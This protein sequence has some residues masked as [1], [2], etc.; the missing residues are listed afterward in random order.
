MKTPENAIS[1][2]S[3]VWIIS[4]LWDLTCLAAAPLA[5]MPLVSLLVPRWVTPEQ[6][7]LLVIAFASV[8]HH[9]PGFLRAYGERDLFFR[10]KWRFLLAPPLVFALAFVFVLRRLHG[11]EL[12]LLLWATWHILMQTYGFMRI[13]DR[14]IG[15]SDRR[16]ATLDLAACLAIFAIGIVFSDAR[17]YGLLEVAWLAG[18]PRVDP[19]LLIIARYAV[20]T[21]AAL[22]SVAYVSNVVWKWNRSGIVA[23]MKLL[24]IGSTAFLY[25][26]SGRLVV[27][28]LV[29]VAVFEIFHALQY[30]AIAWFYGRRLASREDRE[31]GPMGF[32]F[33]DHWWC[34]CLYVAMIAAY[35]S[36]YLMSRQAGTSALPPLAIALYTTSALLHFY[37]DGFI[38]KV[39]EKQTQLNLRIEGPSQPGL[40][41]GWLHATK[42]A[43]L[44][45]VVLGLVFLEGEA[46]P[47]PA[48]R[49]TMLV[50]ELARWTPE[51]PELQ[52][53]ISRN[54]LQRGDTGLAVAAARQALALRPD[55]HRAH[56]DLG[57]A[58]L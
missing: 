50:T 40:V 28:I 47:A 29:G 46:G 56:A 7:S 19:I 6:L 23:W 4:P 43:S 31:F 1:S 36:C 9:L 12:I 22:V 48:E 32:L 5:I 20:G 35:G 16:S 2:R 21:A 41:P 54:A 25:W 37:Y 26:V 38:W 14:K 24:L 18:L 3:S 45:L 58:L 42:C 57:A 34:G 30:N 15:W 44:G 55:S 51:V 39:R 53:R 11:L 10:F 17:M 8:G 27:N 49:E 13:Y 52:S 33:Q